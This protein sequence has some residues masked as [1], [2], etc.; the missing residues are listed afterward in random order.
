MLQLTEIERASGYIDLNETTFFVFDSSLYNLN[1]NH[2][3][4]TGEFRGWD[5]DM[6]DPDW[7]LTRSGQV[8][9]IWT[10]AVPRSSTKAIRPSSPFKFRIDDGQWIDP[11]A[12]A[13]NK[14]SG[15]LI[16]RMGEKPARLRAEMLGNGTISV[17][18]DALPE[19]SDFDPA[20]FR[21]TNAVGRDV[22]L[23]SFK[24]QGSTIGVLTPAEAIDRNRVYYL[25]YP[26]M[27]L[28]T[29]CRRDG[30]MRHLQS[31]KPLGAE[32]AED[33]SQT[34]FRLF[35][36]RATDVRL[37]LYEQAEDE[38]ESK[39]LAMVRDEDGIW[40]SSV[41]SD[42]H[43]IYYDFSVH[44]PSD[45]GNYFY[46]THP[47]RISDPY[48]RVSVDSFGKCRV[49]RATKPA[50]PL[51]NGRPA[52]EDVVAYEVHV[53]DFTLDLPVDEDIKG[54]FA[55]MTKTGLVNDS[56]APVGFDHLKR[57]GVNVIHL[58]PVQE[59]LHY[60]DDVWQEAFADD[61]YM[62]KAGVHK[63]NYQWGYRTTHAFAI[64]TRY[65]TKGTPHGAQRDQFRDMVQAFHDHDMA[66]IIDL[67]P[68]H[69]GEN[70]D[71]RHYLFNFN[72]IDLPYYH[73]TDEDLNHIG[74]F[75]NEIKTED[76]P[77]V[78]RWLI[79]QCKDLIAEFG[80]DGFRIDLAGQIDK[81]SL[82]KLREALD[83]DVIIY[84]EPWIAPSDPDVAANPDWSWYKSDA[85]ITYFQDGARNAFKGPTSDPTIKATDRGF[86]GG[87]ASQRHNVQ[88]AISNGFDDEVVPNRGINYL[89][90]H[91]NWTLADQFATTDWDG[92]K[93][94]DEGPYKVAA[95]L[96]MTSLGPIVVHGGTEMMRSKGLFPN[97]EVTK[98]LPD[99][100]LV[101]HGKKDSYNLRNANLFLWQ[102]AGI[103]P[104][105]DPASHQYT[106][107]INYWRG[108]IELRQS[109]HGRCLRVGTKPGDDYI[110][111]ILPANA[112]HLGYIIDASMM[113]LVNTANDDATFQNVA[114]PAGKWRMVANDSV[115]D[116]NGVARGRDAILRG[117]RLHDVTV[118]KTSLKIFVK[119]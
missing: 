64:E 1:P 89:D 47:V 8:P 49:W 56:G 58:M 18:L 48:A 71:G 66:V 10:L 3:V 79:D 57:L 93:G 81:A 20:D 22:P 75:G 102:N 53:E 76:R 97:Q 115:V 45:P 21:L 112:H 23:Q 106:N 26:A 99:G 62:I 6:Q 34:T 9:T 5:Q 103:D 72:A 12:L 118:P 101:Y 119:D 100:M 15:N 74:P 92:R 83:P 40:E 96:L 59:Y 80:I 37:Y 88:L 46:E 111:W 55:A 51:K 69:T 77:M 105:K 86:A 41:D 28:R 36:P 117:A 33:G 70:M 52:M 91:D 14:Q 110:Q 27:N 13:V 108:L 24:A 42:L 32:V 109:D 11:H 17:S 16:Y 114:L 2:V 39:Q 73:R 25:E 104:E 50:T 38:K 107:M 29:L 60:P 84:G 87:D 30:W 63:S 95:G 54:T 31:S 4:V 82:I 113:V 116:V 35:A 94:V 68:N 7:T 90:I 98:L 78:Q 44:G 65:R 61:P 19:V 85:P 67:V 43:G